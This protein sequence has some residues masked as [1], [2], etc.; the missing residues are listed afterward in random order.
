MGSLSPFGKRLSLAAACEALGMT[1]ASLLRAI[2]AGRIAYVQDR[3]STPGKRGSN[4]FLYE[5]DIEA[6]LASVR[7]VPVTT[8]APVVRGPARMAADV[9]DLLPRERRFA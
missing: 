5:R 4:Y 2:R 1:R 8:S 3:P 9:T 6:Y 7:H